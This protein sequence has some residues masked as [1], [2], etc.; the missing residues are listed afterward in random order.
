MLLKELTAALHMAMVRLARMDKPLLTVVKS[1]PTGSLTV[2]STLTYTVTAT[3]GGNTTLH[4]VV[5]S[6]PLLTPA[7]TSCAG[8]SR[9][10]R[11][12]TWRCR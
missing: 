7:T 11:A 3:N 6:D 12:R 9:S 10:S 5:V 2:G 1:A 8:S 4:N